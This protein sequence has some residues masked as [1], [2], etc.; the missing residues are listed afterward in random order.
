MLLQLYLSIIYLLLIFESQLKN[1]LHFQYIN[2][3]THLSQ[4][5]LVLILCFFFYFDWISKHLEFLM[6]YFMKYNWNFIFFY[7]TITYGL[8]ILCQKNA[9]PTNLK[10]H[11]YHIL[12]VQS[13]SGSGLLWFFSGNL[14]MSISCS[15]VYKIFILYFYFLSELVPFFLIHVIA[16]PLFF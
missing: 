4:I 2:K 9:F 15:F 12:T 11:F 16:P 10:Q 8:K 7:V 6:M 1:F 5:L 14:P 13:I 3:I